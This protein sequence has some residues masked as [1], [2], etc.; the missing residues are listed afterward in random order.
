[1]KMKRVLPTVACALACAVIAGCGD[2][3]QTSDAGPARDPRTIVVVTTPELPP[4]S[5]VDKKTGTIEGID[6]D[7]VR[8]AGKRLGMSVEVKATSFADMLPM[9]KNGEADIAA[10]GITITEGRSRNVDFSTPY[11]VE[12]SA[13]LYR[14]GETVPT[15]VTIEH[16][17]VAVV[18]SMT[19]DFYLAR[20]GVDPIRYFAIEDAIEALRAGK[21]DV[22]MYDRPALKI[23]ADESK[24]RLAVSPLET[25]ERYGIVVSKSRHDIL[26]AV[27][28][29][30]RERNAK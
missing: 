4:Y 6:L 5:Y 18:E 22:V 30:I 21:V 1:M 20:H 3:P 16:L 15:M 14:A 9:V 2:E 7:I 12:G 29:V 23:T 13:F 27:N 24:G 28:E 11:A 19:Q 25:R 26:A 17:R 8:A 10:G